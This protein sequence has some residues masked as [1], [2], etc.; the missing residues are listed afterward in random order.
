MW[1]DVLNPFILL[2]AHA[3]RA[4]GSYLRAIRFWSL[5]HV[6]IDGHGRAGE[7]EGGGRKKSIYPLS[8]NL[9]KYR[10][11]NW[12]SMNSSVLLPIF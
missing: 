8:I 3:L 4:C 9:A 1:V 6:S 2:R 12:G 7:L 10:L 5:M 11:K